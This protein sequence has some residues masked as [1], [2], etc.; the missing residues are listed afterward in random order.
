MLLE[1]LQSMVVLWF[2]IILSKEF[3]KKKPP[4]RINHL[5]YVVSPVPARP[6]KSLNKSSGYKSR[7]LSKSQPLV[8]RATILATTANHSLQLPDHWLLQL[9][10]GKPPY[11]EAHHY[12]DC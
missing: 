8:S 11:M 2:L 3:K 10:V 1:S 12:V 5:P 6:H 4:S 9:V 7:C